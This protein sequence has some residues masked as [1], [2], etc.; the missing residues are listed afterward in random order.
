MVEINPA[1]LAL[2]L[3]T[4]VLLSALLAMF[5]GWGWMFWR[6]A[7]GQSLLPSQPLVSLSPPS[8]RG[9]TVLL[10]FSIYV[11]MNVLVA[12]VYAR[13]LGRVPR[14]P[15]P[16]VKPAG[17]SIKQRESADG[18]HGSKPADKRANPVV[19]RK[20]VAGKIDAKQA[21][22]TTDGEKAPKPTE[23]DEEDGTFSRTEQM[24]LVS[25][26]NCL[27]L[28]VLPILT[29]ATSG[30][31]LRDLGLSFKGWER[32]AAIGVVATLIAAPAVYSIQFASLLIWKANAHP[33]EKMLRKE[34]DGLGVADLAVLSAVILAPI[35]EEFMFR[36]LLQRW[37]IDFLSRRAR[38]RELLPQPADALVPVA[39]DGGLASEQ[40]TWPEFTA[41]V[42]SGSKR[43][44]SPTRAAVIAGI[45]IT[46]LFFAV[47]H[48]PQWP[49]PIPLFALAL[50]IG[51]VY[52]RTGSLIA[53]IFMHATFNSFSTL[54]M[55]VAILGGHEKEA[56]KA[57]DGAWSSPSVV[58]AV[59]R[60]VGGVAA[61]QAM[62]Q[63]WNSN[64]FLL[65]EPV[66]D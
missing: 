39:A 41:T 11:V 9:G 15:A 25:L 63:I 53:A 31:R 1:Q 17:E 66:S 44:G 33:L 56:R 18:E 55:F 37:C 51:S 5:V 28:V 26:I 36:G 14:K 12:G 60:G 22:G 47:V 27:L 46:S 35:V 50:I 2:A 34:F 4:T 20:D 16:A 6:L 42:I 40:K 8:W 54:A 57:I 7:T 59:K 62:W 29:R 61:H 21:H 30:A 19:L 32:Q 24:F 38:T 3:L 48:A 10:A 65:D 52:H 13:A 23:S 45:T 49:A 64:E 43:V 58:A